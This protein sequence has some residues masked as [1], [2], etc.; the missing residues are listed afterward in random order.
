M[1]IEF[2]F[3]PERFLSLFF[4]EVDSSDIWSLVFGDLCVSNEN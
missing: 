2:V 1:T 3:G 4:E